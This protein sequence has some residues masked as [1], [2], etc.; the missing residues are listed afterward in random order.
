M[1]RLTKAALLF[2]MFCM[3]SSAAW[4]GVYSD[5][6]AKCLVKSSTADDQ[7]ALIQWIF[8]AMALHPAVQPFSN[9]SAEQRNTF[10]LKG[11]Q[12]LQRLMTV[13]CRAET[14]AAVK[15]EGPASIEAS[16]SVLGEIAMRGLMSESHVTKGLEG[17]DSHID[18]SKLEAL[19]KEAGV[20]TSTAPAGAPV[21]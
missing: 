16:F 17:M 21:K 3:P 7:L 4:A 13:D 5:D 10:D 9:I 6:M 2:L 12:L 1:A 8:S 19:F 11:A 15:Y 14:I 18:K 20:Q